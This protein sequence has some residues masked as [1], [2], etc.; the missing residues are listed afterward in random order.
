[1]LSTNTPFN[2][3]TRSLVHRGCN[4]HYRRR[5]AGPP[6]L[7]I[8]GTAIHG[9]AWQPQI[10][11]LVESFCCISFDNRGMGRS[12]PVG[13]ALSVA[14]MA[15][16]ALIIMDAENWRSAH[17]V[18]HSLGGLI[19][20]ELALTA[21]ERVRSL[22]LLCTFANGRDAGKLS[23]RMIWIGL[24]TQIGTRRSRRHAFLELVLPPT[25]L[26]NANGDEL[27]ARLERLFGHDLGE[28]PAIMPAQMAAMRD[29]NVHPRLAELKGIATLVVSAV[30][31]PIAPP[32]V[33]Q[34]L[35]SAIPG[36]RYVELADASHGVTFQ[37][38]ER[39]N[40]LLFEHCN[41]VEAQTPAT[42]A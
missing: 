2:G 3:D 35:A 37:Y 41:G 22:S 39:I 16:D 21:P 13:A 14:Q 8:Q 33:G 24:R 27:A 20:L 7:L 25:A 32:A 23:P 6:I 38:P 30:Y 17:I 9:D 42:G 1:M 11:G 36:A 29:H 5:G 28:S 31:D 18:G 19:A 4:L 12:Q 10:D 26:A 34:S 40:Q 15:E